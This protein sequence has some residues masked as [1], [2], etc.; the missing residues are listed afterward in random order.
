MNKHT[1]MLGAAG[2]LGIAVVIGGCASSAER[3]DGDMRTAESAIQQAVSSDARKFEPVLLNQAQNK[4]ADAE[5]LIEQEK[6][7]EAERLL[8]QASVDAQLAGARSDTAKAKQAVEEINGNIESLRQR[9][10]NRQ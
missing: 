3:P 6:Y 9:M 7:I 5:E 2:I 10:E 4:V 8:E 1:S